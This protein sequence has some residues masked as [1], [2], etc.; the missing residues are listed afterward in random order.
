M[1]LT[2]DLSHASGSPLPAGLTLD[3]CLAA[4]RSDTDASTA[5]QH[6]ALH[7]IMP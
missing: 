2:H 4:A 6:H 5:S 7:C 1:L 3:H